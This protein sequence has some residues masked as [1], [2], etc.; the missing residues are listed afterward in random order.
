MSEVVI[1]III[2]LIVFMVVYSLYGR[3]NTILMEGNRYDTFGPRFWAGMVDGI[4][5]AP[6]DYLMVHII[7]V[8]SNLF[9]V[10]VWFAIISLAFSIYSVVMHANWGQTI[11]KMMCKVKVLRNSD[12]RSIDLHLSLIRDS[13]PIV[14]TTVTI[15]YY[16]FKT[17]SG[18]PV[19][20][21]M[22]LALKGQGEP[23]FDLL[24]WIGVLWFVCEIITMLTNKKR[25]ALHD[26]IAGTV[27]VRI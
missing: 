16:L 12:E 23:I 2:A 21:N 7:S 5:F 27:V 26:Y 25:R 11:G 4:I 18:D 10:V 24:T 20:T 8:D 6:F 3:K 15:I 14:L 17:I 9:F 13:V 19:L 1:E 22:I